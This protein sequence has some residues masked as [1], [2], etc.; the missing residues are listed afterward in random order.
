MTTG[1]QE[2]SDEIQKPVMKKR[3]ETAKKSENP[4]GQKTLSYLPLFCLGLQSC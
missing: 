1:T 4:T 3:H 2:Q